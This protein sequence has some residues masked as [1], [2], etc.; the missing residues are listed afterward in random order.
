MGAKA[1]FCRSMKK[2][3][4][5]CLI[6]ALCS[7]HSENKKEAVKI[8]LKPG[9][10]VDTSAMPITEDKLNSSSFTAVIKATGEPGKYDVY[11]AYGYNTAED[12]IA[13]P[14][15][16]ENT[17]PI[18]HKGDSAYTYMVGF[19]YQNKFC[20]YYKISA[21]QGTIKMMYVKSYTFE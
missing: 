10:V 21:N 8:D 2:P 1:Y 18:I 20:D 11:V 3:L 6:A 19:N 12:Q 7:C 13:M 15:G 17:K 5:I 9:S 4:L 16:L 14:K